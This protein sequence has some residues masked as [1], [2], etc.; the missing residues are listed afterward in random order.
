MKHCFCKAVS[1]T[2]FSLSTSIIFA[3]SRAYQ[4]VP[5]GKVFEGKILNITAPNSE[6]WKLA[7][8]DSSGMAFGRRLPEKIKEST[9]ASVAV[10]AA[11]QTDIPDEFEAAIVNSAK[12]DANN[13]RFTTSTFTHKFTNVRGYPC[14]QMQNISEDKNAQT[15]PTTT[16]TQIIQNEHL[17]CRHP[18]QRNLGF[19]ISYSHRGFSQNKDFSKEAASFIEGVFVPST[20]TSK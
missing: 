15:S 18:S 2:I 19:A 17:Y 9:I 7:K 20:T 11:P 6:G 10:F 4:D 8:A 12:V 5:P 3:Q 16:E 14:V 13:E 1:I